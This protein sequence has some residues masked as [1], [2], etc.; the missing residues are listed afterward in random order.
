M[1]LNRLKRSSSAP[2]PQWIIGRTDDDISDSNTF[3]TFDYSYH[4]NYDIV[5]AS[6]GGVD[7]SYNIFDMALVLVDRK[8][9]LGYKVKPICMPFAGDDFTGLDSVIP[10]WGILGSGTS[11]KDYFKEQEIQLQETDT[12]KRTLGKFIKFHP[13]S[14]LCGPVLSYEPCKVS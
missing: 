5:T 8:I 12:C 6:I 9:P 10:G 13:K 1:C 2:S 7:K 4:P 11:P 14:M 3:L